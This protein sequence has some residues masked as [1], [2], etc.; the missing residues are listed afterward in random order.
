MATALIGFE[1]VDNLLSPKDQMSVQAMDKVGKHYML[2]WY[3]FDYH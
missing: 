2:F 3:I 1:D